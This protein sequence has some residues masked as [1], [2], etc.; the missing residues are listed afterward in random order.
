[1]ISVIVPVY[2]VEAYL[3]RCVDSLLQQTVTDTEI[4]L[5]DDGS[6]DHCG[7]LC[8]RYARQDPR[9]TVIHK[10]NGGL[11]DARNAGLSVAKG[12]YVAFVDSDDWVSEQFLQRLLEGLR[13]TDSDICE[14]GIYHTEGT[15]AKAPASPTDAECFDT[16]SAMEQLLRNGTFRQHVWNKLYRREVIGDIRFPVGKTN[17]DEFWT[18]QVFGRAG[19][20]C[21]IED[22]LYNY[23]QRPGS[24]MNAGYSLKRLHGLEAKQ[25]RQRYIEENYPRL[26]PQARADLWLSCLYAGQMSLRYLSGADLE[27]AVKT[28]DHCLG[29]AAADR[30]MLRALPVGTAFWAVISR[31]SFWG[32]CRLRNML[33]RGL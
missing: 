19:K 13:H 10:S 21:R 1:M 6:T 33:R 7:E 11:S 3:C 28:I 22:I 29:Q 23:F 16:A 24:I 2:N 12:A 9:V 20:V 31:F 17:E 8:D 4:I 26:A 15:A 27:T 14:C 25:V 30:R 32:V 5:V 18:Y